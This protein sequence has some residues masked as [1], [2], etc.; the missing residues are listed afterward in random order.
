MQKVLM[1]H[2]IIVHFPDK[3]N[4]FLLTPYTNEDCNYNLILFLVFPLYSEQ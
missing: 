1:N 4:H 2:N 3:C